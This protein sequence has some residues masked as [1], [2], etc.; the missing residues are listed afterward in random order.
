L[1]TIFGE[2]ECS[3]YVYREREE[4]RSPIV[5]RPVD[6]QLGISPDR[7]SPLL[8]E[9]SMLFCLEQ[10]FHSAVSGFEKVF[11]QQLSVDTLE[12]VSQKMGRAAEEFLQQLKA[13][14][15]KDGQHKLVVRCG[16]LPE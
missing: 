1:R 2:H 7:Y 10:S 13:P 5:R 11:R 14:K 3:A 8:Q 4:R 6:K 16:C 15:K 12:K 9:Y